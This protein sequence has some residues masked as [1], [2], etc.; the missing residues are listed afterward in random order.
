[1]KDSVEILL[2]EDNPGDVLLTQTAFKRSH[3]VNNLT[4][5]ETAEEAIQLLRN[6]GDYA[7]SKRPDLVLLDLNLPRM[8]GIEFLQI[9]KHDATLKA[10]PVVVL[11]SSDAEADIQSSYEQYANS[12]ITKPVSLASFVDV[13]DCLEGFWFEIVRLPA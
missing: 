5:V 6:E 13:L 1:M 12:F 3:I 10:I 9:V 2:V 4:C 7:Q 11:T 8:S